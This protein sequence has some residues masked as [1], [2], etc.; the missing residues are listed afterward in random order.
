M[1]NITTIYIKSLIQEHKQS[2][3]T[4]TTLFMKAGEC[5]K[6]VTTQHNVIISV[7]LLYN[8]NFKYT[9]ITKVRAEDY[10]LHTS[11]VHTLS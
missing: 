9:T 7:V 6:Q 10:I 5:I 4:T 3:A 8:T 11:T 1:N 2:I